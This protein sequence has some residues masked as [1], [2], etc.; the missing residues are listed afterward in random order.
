M[1]NVEHVPFV[2]LT[3][4]FPHKFLLRFQELV[5]L[6]KTVASETVDCKFCICCLRNFL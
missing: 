2:T 3:L 1:W 6:V 4:F 5:L